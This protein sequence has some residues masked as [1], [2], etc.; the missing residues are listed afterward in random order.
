MSQRTAVF[1]VT[2]SPATTYRN[3]TT[4]FLV[5]EPQLERFAP[6]PPPPPPVG[7]HLV[8]AIAVIPFGRVNCSISS[9]Y[10]IFH[11]TFMLLHGQCR[12]QIKEKQSL[13]ES[14]TFQDF[15]VLKIIDT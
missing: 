2:T 7:D 10:V 14:V 6:P 9:V 11:E 8:L 13:F 12:L 15:L 5:K 4:I 1:C 3:N